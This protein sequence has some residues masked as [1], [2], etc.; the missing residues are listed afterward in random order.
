MNEYFE[1]IVETKGIIVSV[2]SGMGKIEQKL[3]T[4]GKI[5]ICIDPNDYGKKDRYTG[6]K[7]VLYPD[8]STV[9]D[10]LLKKPLSIG[11][12]NLLL[13]YPLPD[14]NLYDIMAIKRL[15]PKNIF[16]YYKKDGCAGSWFLHRFLRKNKITTRG[17]IRMDEHVKRIFFINENKCLV[18]HQYHKFFE[19]DDYPYSY[20]IL[21]RGKAVEDENFIQDINF[22]DVE[23]FIL[24][25]KLSVQIKFGK[26]LDILKNKSLV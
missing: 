15:E 3:R 22:E 9:A 18:K 20:L 12:I 14:Y 23:E 1:K 26:N 5:V 21:T 25:G 16:L 4:S 11:K 7:R 2:G 8:Y 6:V 17:K 13:Q 19:F 10:F 24:E